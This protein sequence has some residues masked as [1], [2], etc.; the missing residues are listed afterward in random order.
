MPQNPSAVPRVSAELPIIGLPGQSGFHIVVPVFP[1]GDPRNQGGP[2]GIPGEYEVTFTL[3]RPGY[4]LQPERSITSCDALQGDSHL[5]IPKIFQIAIGAEGE[6]FNVEGKPNS[7]EFLAA[8]VVKCNAEGI[9]AA[10][11]KCYK[12]VTP[13]LSHFSLKWDVP[14]SIYQ[15]DV[16][17]V[18]TGIRGFSNRNPFDEV[19]IKGQFKFGMDQEPRTYAAIYREAIT[20]GNITYQFL[21]FYRLIESIQARRTRLER[22][23]RRQATKYIIPTEVYPRN[24]AEAIRFLDALFSPKAS[25][26]DPLTLS[27]ILVSD[28]VGKEFNKIVSVYLK[29]IRINIAH[30]LLQRASEL[31]SMDDPFSSRRIETWLP[32]IKCI[33]RAMLKNEFGFIFQ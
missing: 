32:P 8:L 2:S 12:V 1:E 30:T 27:M 33:A 11:D 22:E 5:G 24:E 10:Y 20:T 29:P 23:C 13:L 16:K 25:H 3:G 9:S 7:K 6:T 4:P 15:V 19:N 18:R 26:S 28:A 14:L 17:E 31:I 21:C